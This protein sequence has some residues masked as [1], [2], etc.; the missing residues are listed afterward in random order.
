[1]RTLDE[2]IA[3]FPAEQRAEIAART[4]KLIA[5]L[6]RMDLRAPDPDPSGKKALESEAT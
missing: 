6:P 5:L 2:V 3:S 1:M 4:Q